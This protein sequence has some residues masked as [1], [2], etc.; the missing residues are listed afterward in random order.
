MH[1]AIIFVL[2]IPFAESNYSD[3]DADFLDMVLA[4]TSGQFCPNS[5]ALLHLNACKITFM[6]YRVECILILVPSPSDAESCAAYFS[7]AECNADV[8]GPLPDSVSAKQ[9]ARYAA[10]GVDCSKVVKVDSPKR[11]KG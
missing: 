8:P 11:V 5:Q 10:L 6:I 9:D 2:T 4:S 7:Y 1:A 3:C